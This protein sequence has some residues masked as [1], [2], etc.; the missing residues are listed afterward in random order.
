MGAM[1]CVDMCTLF[2]L[3]KLH[4]V[5]WLFFIFPLRISRKFHCLAK[6]HRKGALSKQSS[7]C[8]CILMRNDRQ[9]TQICQSLCESAIFALEL[10][11]FYFISAVAKNQWQVLRAMSSSYLLQFIF[12]DFPANNIRVGRLSRSGWVCFILPISS[13]FHYF[14]FVYYAAH[15][16]TAKNTEN[17]YNYEVSIMK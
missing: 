9:M 11:S 10:S 1:I 4:K 17:L 13:R 14:L 3:R 6:T 5:G 12:S 15:I 7:S 16:M 2:N 8:R